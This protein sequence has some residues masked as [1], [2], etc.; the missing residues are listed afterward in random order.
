MSKQYLAVLLAGGRAPWL[1]QYSHT[2]I[3]SLA[4][5]Q[6]RTVLEQLLAAIKGSGRIGGLLVVADRAALEQLRQQLPP[7]VQLCEAGGNM[8]NTCLRAVEALQAEDDAQLLFLCDD[9]PLLTGEAL[10]DFL[11]RCEAQPDAQAYYPIISRAHCLKAYPKAKRTYGRVAEG[12]FTG[13]NLF[14]T[15]AGAIRKGQRAAQQVFALRKS[16]FRLG[17]WLGWTFILRLLLGILSLEQAQKRASELF[18]FS[19]RAIITPYA[20]IGMDMDKPEDWLLME[21]HLS[22]NTQA[23]SEDNYGQS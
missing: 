19:C 18:G 21:E 7:Q 3:R 20:A 14:L 4:R 12:S 8:P 6:G 15:T 13:G 2:D 23:R 11:D 1:Q 9:I 17:C 10:K 5:L 16:P 22:T